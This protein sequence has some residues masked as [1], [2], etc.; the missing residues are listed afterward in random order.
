M[1]D[2]DLTTAEIVALLKERGWQVPTPIDGVFVG[3][4][5]RVRVLNLRYSF[6]QIERLGLDKF[7]FTPKAYYES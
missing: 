3:N 7:K 4:T 5:V 6:V 2:L 1:M